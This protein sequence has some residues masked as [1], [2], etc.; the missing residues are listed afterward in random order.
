MQRTTPPG[1]LSFQP[2]ATLGKLTAAALG[3][4]ALAFAI[5][6]LTILLA[7]GTII[8]PLVL[9]AVALLIVAGIV[10]TG[11]RWT[12][13]LGALT[14]LWTMIGGVFTQ[15]YF[16]YHLTHPAEGGPFRTCWEHLQFPELMITISGHDGDDAEKYQVKDVQRILK[17]LGGRQ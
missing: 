4:S 17:E 10:F 9:V 14:G 11:M 16:V 2:L 12:P 3:A 15:Q 7:T 5:L 13:L 6:A 8:Q 1:F